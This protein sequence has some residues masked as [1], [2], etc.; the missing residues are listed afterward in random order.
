MS[1][2]RQDQFWALMIWSIV[3]IV[4]WSRDLLTSLAYAYIRLEST[5]LNHITSKVKVNIDILHAWV[6]NQIKA[7][8]CNTKIVAQQQGWSYQWNTQLIE[9]SKHSHCFLCRICKLTIF[10]FGRGPCNN[11]LFLWTLW[12]EIWAKEADVSKCEC[13][14]IYIFSPIDI[15]ISCES[16]RVG[17]YELD[18]IKYAVF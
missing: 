8:L 16:G 18:F 3:L 5:M 4:A 2:C 15:R 7:K 14:V 11:S 12:N 10:S 1:F 13:A 17:I 9:E 6:L